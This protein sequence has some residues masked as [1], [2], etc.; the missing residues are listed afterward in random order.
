MVLMIGSR[1]GRVVAV[2]LMV[3]RQFDCKVQE[4]WFPLS[5][6][7]G[8][9]RKYQQTYGPAKKGKRGKTKRW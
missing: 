7:S 9:K 4:G 6:I 5:D 3:S 1:V 2:A 8:S